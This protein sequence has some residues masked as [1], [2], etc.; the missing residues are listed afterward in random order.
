MTTSSSYPAA[1]DTFIES[2]TTTAQRDAFVDDLIRHNTINKLSAAVVAEQSELGL[3]PAGSAATVVARLAANDTIGGI[4]SGAVAGGMVAETNVVAV[5]SG[6]GVV[7][8]TVLTATDLVI[9]LGN[10]TGVS[11]GTVTVATFPAGPIRILGASLTT[12]LSYTFPGTGS[13]A[14]PLVGTMGGDYSFGTVGTLNATLDGT[15]VDIIPSTGID[16]L[17]TAVDNHLATPTDTVYDGTSTAIDINLSHIIDDADV[18][19]GH[20]ENV[21]VSF[22]LAVYW[23]NYGDY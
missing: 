23:I 8:K 14:E 19:N 6:N 12:G 4:T 9:V 21:Q 10:T 7:H 11:F 2:K 17:S 1:A 18:S 5:E 13:Q 15:A 3:D 16:P 22:V 20:S